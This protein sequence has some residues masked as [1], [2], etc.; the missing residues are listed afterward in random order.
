MNLPNARWRQVRASRG[1]AALFLA[2]LAAG[3]GLAGHSAPTPARIAPLD[4][5]GLDSLLARQW[6]GDSTP[7]VGAQKEAGWIIAS[8]VDSSSLFGIQVFRFHRRRFLT[9]DR[10]VARAGPQAVWL[11]T[12][13]FWLPRLPRSFRL[14][15]TCARGTQRDP[16]LLAVVR[17]TDAEWFTDVRW[18]WRANTATGRFE[19]AS[20]QGVRCENEGWGA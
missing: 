12:D 6:R 1:V 5:Q 2:F 4:R 18:V 8:P 9:F 13:V 7:L 19:P 16:E 17:F 15:S 14:V 10:G 3:C 20:S 11:I